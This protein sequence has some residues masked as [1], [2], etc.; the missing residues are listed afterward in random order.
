MDAHLT[1]DP[2]AR[3]TRRGVVID[4][5]LGRD[6]SFANPEVCSE[7]LCDGL[8]DHLPLWADVSF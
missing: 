1:L 2:K 8:S 4:L 7:A 6:V 3:P 5:L